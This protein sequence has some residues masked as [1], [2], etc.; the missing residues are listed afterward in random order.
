[1]ARYTKI[2]SKVGSLRKWLPEVTT[3][4]LCLLVVGTV[5]RAISATE[6]GKWL[7]S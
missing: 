3:T 1:M 6:E 4:L 7:K 5:L 2:G